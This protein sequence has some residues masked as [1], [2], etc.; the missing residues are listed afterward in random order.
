MAPHKS[1]ASVTGQQ[2]LQTSVFVSSGQTLAL[3][4]N[5]RRRGKLSDEKLEKGR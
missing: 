2:S 4:E 5:F 1:P 3:Q